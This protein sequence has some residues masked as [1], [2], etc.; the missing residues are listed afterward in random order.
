[1]IGL[2][3][4]QG[5]HSN[6]KAARR[7]ADKLKTHISAASQLC[8]D[9]DEGLVALAALHTKINEFNETQDKDDFESDYIRQCFLYILQEPESD[10]EM[11]FVVQTNYTDVYHNK[12]KDPDGY[13]L[14]GERVTVGSTFDFLTGEERQAIQLLLQ[15]SP[16]GGKSVYNEIL[17]QPQDIHI[18]YEQIGSAFIIIRRGRSVPTRFNV[19]ETVAYTEPVTDDEW[20]I[21]RGYFVFIKN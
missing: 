5:C 6:E 14:D 12:F 19:V 7:D 2:F 15:D 16:Q 21:E 13:G 20:V 8:A 17:I 9:H 3:V 18:F 4:T 10:S 11:R 1:V